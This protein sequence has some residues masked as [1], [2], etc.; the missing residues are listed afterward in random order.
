[1]EDIFLPLKDTVTSLPSHS[2][3]TVIS[4]DGLAGLTGEQSYFP[5]ATSLLIP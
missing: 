5:K 2:D 3:A 4:E 1:M